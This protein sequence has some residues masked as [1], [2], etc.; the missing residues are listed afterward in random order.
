[1]PVFEP[2]SSSAIV[3]TRYQISDALRFEGLLTGTDLGVDR[4]ANINDGV[5]TVDSHE[6]VFEPRLRFGSGGRF[7]GVAGLYLYRSD[8]DETLDFLAFQT[9]QDRTRTAA[10]F[11]E[12]TIPLGGSPF[13]LLAGAR[14]ERS[15]EHTS[16]LQSLMRISYAVFCLKKKKQKKPPHNT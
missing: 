4:R 14:Y 12:A 8:Q 10:A 1:M 11:G 3:D 13:D 16:E 15:E 7:S 6:Y 9:Y 2:K 5:A